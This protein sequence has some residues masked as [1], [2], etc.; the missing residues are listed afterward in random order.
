LR[1]EEAHVPATPSGIV[2]LLS[3]YGI[4]V[5]RKRIVVVGRT[6]EV[7]RALTLLCI[8]RG[9]AVV[10]VVDPDAGALA[11]TTRVG[12]IVVSAAQ[13]PAL[14]TRESVALGAAVVD[15]AANRT[16]WGIVGDVDE[17]SIE[18]HAGALAP[19]PGGIGPATIAA[20]LQNTWAA[21]R[22]QR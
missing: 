7:A 9:A 1:G 5:E 21:A 10:T 19:M 12:D 11:E 13:R 22:A 4:D 18:G 8:Q 15:A 20:L 14:I 3:F 2:Q 6:P 16:A 17:R